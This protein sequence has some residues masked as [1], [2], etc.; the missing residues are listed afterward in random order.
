MDEKIDEKIDEN[1]LVDESLIDRAMKKML[2]K[3]IDTE[4]K[5]KKML[6]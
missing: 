4:T 5:I 1:N 6:G 2:P 3:S